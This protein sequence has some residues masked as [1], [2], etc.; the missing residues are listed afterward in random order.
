MKLSQTRSQ[1]FQ[2]K[3]KKYLTKATSV[4]KRNPNFIAA[5]MENMEAKVK[6]PPAKV[7]NNCRR[8]V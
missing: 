6:R 4:I 5:I 7:F 3:K 8:G 1:D 2:I